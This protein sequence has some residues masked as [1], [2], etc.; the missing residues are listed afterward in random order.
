MAVNYKIDSYIDVMKFTCDA[1][2]REIVRLREKLKN[3]NDIKAG[4]DDLRLKG[5]SVEEKLYDKVKV[6]ISETEK[7]IE[8]I[9]K[10][11]LKID[12]INTRL[13]DIRRLI[14]DPK[15]QDVESEKLLKPFF[16]TYKNEYDGTTVSFGVSGGESQFKKIMK[17]TEVYEKFGKEV[18]LLNAKLIKYQSTRRAN[19]KPTNAEEI[20]IKN[21]IKRYKRKQAKAIGKQEVVMLRREAI[22]RKRNKKISRLEAKRDLEISKGR[23]AISDKLEE[24]ITNLKSK[25]IRQMPANV[26]LFTQYMSDFA[27]RRHYDKKGNVDKRQWTDRRIEALQEKSR[28]TL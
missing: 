27:R 8:K 24:K 1:V 5:L 12:I 13:N 4:Y 25:K 15:R 28:K 9:E 6:D 18:D 2:S 7:K 14:P 3:Y 19:N 22:I 21:N 10:D 23:T 11:K 26:I 17:Q 20:G 16:T